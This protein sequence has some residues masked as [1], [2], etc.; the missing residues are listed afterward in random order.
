MS[1][2][3]RMVI[4]LMLTSSGLF[5]QEVKTENIVIVTLDGYRWNEL[6]KGADPK[7]IQSGRYVQDQQ[8]RL[9]FGGETEGEKRSKLMPFMWNVVARQGQ[10]YGNRRHRNKVN[11]VNN[12]LLSYPGYSEMLVGFLER[13]VSSNEKKVNP[14][15]TVLEF[16][17]GHQAFHKKVVAFGTWDTFPYIFREQKADF[18]V[19]AGKEFAEGNISP[20]ERRVN[21]QLGEALIRT[22]EH[23]FNF[24]FEYL[25]RERPRVM[26]IGFDGTDHHAHG[27]RYDQYLRSAHRIDEMLRELWNWLQSE[28]AYMDRT[29]LL[30]TTDHGRGH[31]RHS[32]K[33]HRLFARGSRQ[34]WMAVIGPDTPAFGELKFR[35]KHY[36]KQVAK[37][38]AAFLGLNYRPKREPG[39]IIHTM[40]AVPEPTSS[41][42]FTKPSST[43]QLFLKAGDER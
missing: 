11:C 36:Q 31:G 32:W 37:T 33:H 35:G 5:S 34:I 17:H 6:F 12:H 9:E 3:A 39:E 15:A 38:V 18:L 30:I 25:K 43:D 10:L 4:I 42:S 19:N 2:K 16:I 22:D 27:G 14:N 21:A 41:E 8:V 29:T 40:I 1:L 7:I 26:F 24:A 23:T 13:S 20:A 28:P